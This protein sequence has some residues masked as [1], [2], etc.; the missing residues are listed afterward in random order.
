LAGVVDFP[1]RAARK[2]SV[3]LFVFL[4]ATRATERAKA[5]SIEP[6]SVCIECIFDKILRYR[7]LKERRKLFLGNFPG[8]AFQFQE[9]NILGVRRVAGDGVTR[10][11]K[12]QVQVVV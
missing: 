8:F 12:E 2:A 4:D 5:P 7:H 11:M 10:F 9:A 3:V 1:A 6:V